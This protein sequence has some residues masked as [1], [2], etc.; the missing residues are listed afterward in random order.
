MC[1]HIHWLALSEWR[2]SIR[3]CSAV[4]RPSPVG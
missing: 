4:M 3:R 1:K 2:N